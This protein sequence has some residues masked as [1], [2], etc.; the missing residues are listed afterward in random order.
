MKSLTI[1]YMNGCP[2][3]RMAKRA[4]DELQDADGRFSEVPVRWIEE[5]R[6][7]EAAA[8]YSD[9]WYVPSLYLEDRKLYEASPA[10]RYE[11]ILAQVRRALELAAE[12]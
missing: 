12:A 3:C 6:E 10:D 4:L 1:L 9:Y 11:D 2:Y 8:A 5:N 7:T